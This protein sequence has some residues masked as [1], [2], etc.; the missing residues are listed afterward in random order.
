MS[1]KDD[2]KNDRNEIM[3]EVEKHRA[4]IVQLKKEI[5]DLKKVMNL[6]KKY[7]D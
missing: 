3:D 7:L 2:V 1:T 6:R 4:E 5:Q